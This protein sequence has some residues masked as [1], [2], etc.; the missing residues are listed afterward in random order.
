MTRWGTVD[1]HCEIVVPV[2]LA[3]AFPILGIQILEQ[4]ICRYSLESCY[5][6]LCMGAVQWLNSRAWARLSI[7]HFLGSFRV[8][9]QAKNKF[10]SKP[11]IHCNVLPFSPFPA[12]LP[13]PLPRLLAGLFTVLG[14]VAVLCSQALY[15]VLRCMYTE[16]Y[17]M[18]VGAVTE[19]KRDA[20]RK[21]LSFHL[22]YF[23]SFSSSSSSLRRI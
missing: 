10:R 4:I 18:Y 12:A 8:Q 7:P 14:F 9:S 15:F 22:P 1:H 19:R 3:F 16:W 11:K 21:V 13:L 2:F 5:S 17:W 23:C 20:K 6:Q